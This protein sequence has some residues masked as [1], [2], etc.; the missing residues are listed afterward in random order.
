[1]TKNLDGMLEYEEFT[2]EDFLNPPTE[3][4]KQEYQK[5]QRRK[6]DKQTLLALASAIG[7]VGSVWIAGN[8]FVTKALIK[9]SAKQQAKTTIEQTIEAHN[10]RVPAT[11][12]EHELPFTAQSFTAQSFTTQ[13]F[14]QQDNLKYFTHTISKH[15]K[16]YSHIANKYGLQLTALLKANN[17]RLPKN[18]VLAMITGKKIKIPVFDFR[19]SITAFNKEYSN[20]EK[21]KKTLSHYR[22][23]K[24]KTIIPILKR[25]FEESLNRYQKNAPLRSFVERAATYCPNVTVKDLIVR[26]MVESGFQYKQT[27]GSDAI[28][29]W[30]IKKSK[31]REIINKNNKARR[32][33]KPYIKE[34]PRSMK[35]VNLQNSYYSVF[36]AALAM[37]DSYDKIR[38]QERLSGITYT[39]EQRNKLEES[40][41]NAGQGSIYSAR[42]IPNSNETKGFLLK[43]GMARKIYDQQIRKRNNSRLANAK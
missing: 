3:K 31:A 42:G 38:I 40:M 16:T 43:H 13:S 7:I 37:Q 9:K 25:S 23:E 14:T 18:G 39:R 2:K 28:G 33:G 15:D 17:L 4:E 1:M 30:Q 35:E 21:R 36:I 11:A 10:L 34:L 29:Y 22:P 6:S 26:G 27:S 12:L 41:Y 20:L 19:P 32:I 5:Q 8:Y 24:R